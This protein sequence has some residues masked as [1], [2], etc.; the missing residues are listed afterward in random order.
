MLR[1]GSAWQDVAAQVAMTK[2]GLD[3]RFISAPMT[4]TPHWF[5]M[6]TWTGWFAMPYPSLP[7]VTAIQ[8][9]TINTA[10][11]FGLSRDIGPLRPIAGGLF[12]WW[13]T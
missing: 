1:Y 11:H 5:R 12:Y 4:C 9:A 6:V 8:M 3:A 2:M 13:T 10:E 7:P